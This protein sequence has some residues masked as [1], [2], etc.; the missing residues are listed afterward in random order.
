MKEGGGGPLAVPHPGVFF[1]EGAVSPCALP[2]PARPRPAPPGPLPLDPS[3]THFT[4]FPAKVLVTDPPA[5]SLLVSP[6][7]S[8]EPWHCPVSLGVPTLLQLTPS[9]PMMT[10]PKEKL[11][12]LPFSLAAEEPLGGHPLLPVS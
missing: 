11:S 8:D 7:P 12:H 3:P 5:C 9:A 1:W 6:Q 2:H 4:S 10:H